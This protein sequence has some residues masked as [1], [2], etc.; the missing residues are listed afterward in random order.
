MTTPNHYV[1][2]LD[3]IS[4]ESTHPRHRDW[5]DVLSWGYGVRRQLPAFMHA[6][7]DGDGAEGGG[8]DSEANEVIFDDFKFTHLVD[9][10]S[11]ALRRHCADGTLIPTVELCWYRAG[12]ASSEYARFTLSDCVVTGVAAVGG[13]EAMEHVSLAY[14]S[15]RIQVSELNDDGELDTTVTTILV[16]G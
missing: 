4:G 13:I 16:K 15:I 5:I 1:I 11:P 6:N 14:G 7:D 3:G 8:E 12:D 9:K 10:S 2:K